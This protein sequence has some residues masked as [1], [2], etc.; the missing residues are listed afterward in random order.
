MIKPNKLKRNSLKIIAGLGVWSVPIVSFVSLPAHAQTSEAIAKF[1]GK[2]LFTLEDGSTPPGIGGIDSP[3]GKIYVEIYSNGTFGVFVPESDP[4]R[5]AGGPYD[6]WFVDD[7][8]A[9]RF[10]APSIS[11]FLME[12]QPRFY[13]P[14]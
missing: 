6:G 8:G 3:G 4:N 13:F 10:S 12:K 2:W 5:Q 14:I 9:F 7:N 1:S 11:W